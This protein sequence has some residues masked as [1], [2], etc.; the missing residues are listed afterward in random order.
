M[1]FTQSSYGKVP[2][3]PQ[4]IHDPLQLPVANQYN[5][6]PMCCDRISQ[7]LPV[8][9]TVW[10]HPYQV[11]ANVGL[12]KRPILQSGSLRQ[13]ERGGGAIKV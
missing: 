12:Y 1:I 5:D 11:M 8:E 13:M 10:T 2:N 6:P 9:S 4:V 7:N 3:P